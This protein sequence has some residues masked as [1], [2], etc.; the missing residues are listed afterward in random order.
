MDDTIIDSKPIPSSMRSVYPKV[1]NHIAISVPDLDQAIKWYK[2]FGFHV[3][4][5]PVKFLP[6]NSVFG[7]RLDFSIAYLCNFCFLLPYVAKSFNR[8]GI[9]AAPM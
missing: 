3:I 4:A 6:D 1:I 8:V 7:T 5:G 9:I 2:V